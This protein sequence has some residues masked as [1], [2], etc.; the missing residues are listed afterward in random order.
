MKQYDITCITNEL[1][2]VPESI[3]ECGECI[4]CCIGLS[5]HLTPAEFE[6]GEYIY[7]LY[8]ASGSNSNI[9]VI[10][11]PRTERGCIYLHENKC[12]IYDRRPLSCR[13]FDCR[14]G[15]YPP[16]KDIALD[17]FGEY[18]EPKSW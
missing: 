10:A 8:T 17:K 3:V 16:F 1:R 14:K 12:T 11:I 18:D 13:Q 15:H 2:D 9:P 6:S 5:P 7:T 4:Q